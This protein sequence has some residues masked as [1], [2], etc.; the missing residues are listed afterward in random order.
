MRRIFGN[1]RA[2]ILDQ[3]KELLDKHG[4][5]AIPEAEVVDLITDGLKANINTTKYLMSDLGWTKWEVKWG[6]VD[7]GRQIWVRPGYIVQNGKISG[8]DGFEEKLST[9]LDHL[10]FNGKQLDLI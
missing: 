10:S 7:Y 3:M 5:N 2:T 9:H 6:K 8:P 1:G 4:R